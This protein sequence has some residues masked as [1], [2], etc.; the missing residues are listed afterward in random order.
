MSDPKRHHWWPILQSK[1]WT[2]PDGLI[3]VTRADGTGYRVNPKNIGLEGD[4]YT[5][6]ALTGEK[7]LTI[8]RWFSTEIEGPFRATLD[9]L[10]SLPGRQ[11]VPLTLD[12]AKK[13]E[14]KLLGFVTN[15]YRESISLPPDHRLSLSKYLAALLVRNPRYIRKLVEFHEERTKDWL[16]KKYE[17]LDL[18]KGIRTVALENMVRTFNIYGEQIVRSDFM[19][20]RNETKNEFVF[21]DGG[22]VADEPWSSAVPFT[23]HAPLTPSLAVEVL[24]SP[25]P[26]YRD[27][28]F[29]VE[30]STVGVK[31]F[32]RISLQDSERFVFTRS[33]PPS[34]FIVRY[35]GKPAPKAFGHRWING[36]LETKYDKSLDC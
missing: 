13:E 20:L 16:S 5:R 30:V 6:Y 17:G 27:R 28:A 21:S 35:F 9:F 8:E 15:D 29:L 26:F 11:R 23:I 31:R 36:R 34:D 24:P 1:H 3:H 18:E 7:D 25:K 19:F 4:L 14:S 2:G 22:I 32:N 10:A 12:P 33:S